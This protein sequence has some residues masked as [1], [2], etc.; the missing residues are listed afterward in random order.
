MAKRLR[1]HLDESIDPAVATGLRNT[2]IDATTSQESGLLHAADLEQLSFAAEQGRVL[3][4]HDADFLRLAAQG[5]EHCG[6]AYCPVQSRS[7]GEIIRAI[8]LMAQ[9]LE[10][11]EMVG[12]VE[13]L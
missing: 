12:R 8:V 2:G 9:I 11:R 1:F 10:P 3:V 4:T 6:I 7:L 13:Y 5:I